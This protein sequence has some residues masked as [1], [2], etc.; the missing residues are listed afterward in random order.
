MVGSCH[1]ASN[2]SVAIVGTI[3]AMVKASP[4]A[5]RRLATSA[6]KA[7]RAASTADSARP[8]LTMIATAIMPAGR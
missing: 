5:N 8:R 6:G 3:T 7:V 1:S 4:R 2:Q